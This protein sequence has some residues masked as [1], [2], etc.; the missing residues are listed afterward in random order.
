[1]LEVSQ[2]MLDAASTD[3]TAVA[4]DLHRVGC[5]RTTHTVEWGAGTSAGVVTIEAAESTAYAGTWHSLATVTWGAESTTE[6]I[7]LQPAT[8]RTVEERVLV[9][10]RY[11]TVVRTGTVDSVRPLAGTTHV[12]SVEEFNQELASI[13]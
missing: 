2:R 7:T 11:V 4:I 12:V 13:R 1:M 10:A 6:T 8:T 5:E 3:E 9:P